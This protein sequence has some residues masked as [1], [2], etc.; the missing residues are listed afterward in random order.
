P[1]RPEISDRLQAETQGG[2][3]GEQAAPLQPQRM[4]PGV[5]KDRTASR[6]AKPDVPRSLRPQQ[7]LQ[8]AAGESHFPGK[9]HP[10]AEPEDRPLA[11]IDRISRSDLQRSVMLDAEER[12][13]LGLL[14]VRRLGRKG[15]DRLEDAR[16][17]TAP[18]D[19]LDLADHAL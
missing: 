1:V 12:T 13:V 8:A 6:V 11:D 2:R 18:E 10:A 19:L 7:P 15:G 5:A 16:R 3:Q 17:N 14:A 9:A 4:A